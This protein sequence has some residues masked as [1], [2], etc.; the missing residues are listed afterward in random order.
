MTHLEVAPSL[1][2]HAELGLGEYDAI[3][4][5]PEV[6]PGGRGGREDSHII[7]VAIR[8]TFLVQTH[9]LFL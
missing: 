1:A 5:R 4:D 2:E 9:K 7:V 8:L 6:T 3:P